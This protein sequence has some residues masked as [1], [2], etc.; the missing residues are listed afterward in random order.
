MRIFGKCWWQLG[1]D[2]ANFGE[3]PPGSAGVLRHYVA[4]PVCDWAEDYLGCDHA[5]KISQLCEL[6]IGAFLFVSP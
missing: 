6:C 1:Q 2:A 4:Q 3:G 5:L